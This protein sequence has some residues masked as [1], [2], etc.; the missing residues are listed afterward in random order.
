[1]GKWGKFCRLVLVL[2]I[3]ALLFLTI[4]LSLS[5][6]AARLQVEDLQRD[7]D[8]YHALAASGCVTVE[9]VEGVARANGWTSARI[10]DGRLSVRR[11][12]RI[13]M[14]KGPDASF[15]T[16]GPDGCLKP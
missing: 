10:D 9:Q 14:A 7:L 4:R 2:S 6:T 8:V 16:F 12:D 13:S 5:L 1:M 15:L 3:P 11:S